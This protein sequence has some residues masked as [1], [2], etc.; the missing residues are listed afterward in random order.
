MSFPRILPGGKRDSAAPPGPTRSS[1]RRRVCLIG[2]DG[3]PY[4][5]LQRMLAEGVMPNL[6]ALARTGALRRMHS[7]YPWV[8]SVAWAS[9]MTGC[10]PAKHNIFGFIDR[11]PATWQ[12]FIPTADHMRAPTLWRLLSQA[13][14]RVVVLNVPVSY[15]V[16]SQ[17]VNGVLIGCFLSPRL[18]ERSVYPPSLLPKL[19]EL[20]YRIDTNPWLARQ[21]R[22]QILADILD[23]LEKRAATALYLLQHED[24][25]FFMAVLM[26]TD[27]LHHFF[28]RPMEEN[29]PTWAPA[30]FDL[31]RRIDQ[32]IG[33]VQARLDERTTLLLMSDHG[34]CS[35]KQE[36]FYNT[37]LADAGYL[38]YAVPPAT[39]KGPDLAAIDPEQS[40]AYS[41][42]PGRIFIN[43]AG[44]EKGGRVQPAGYERL[45]DELAAAAEALVD[46]RSGE[47]LV[48]KAYRREELYH[49]PYVGQAADLILAP[50]DGYDPKG[51]FG[52]ATLTA[53]DPALVGMHTYEDAFLCAA[54]V[55]LAPDGFG[56]VD[57]MP[58]ILELL[59]TPAPAHVD[60]RSLLSAAS[61]R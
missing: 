32:I 13:G 47:R 35:I 4:S 46:P 59:D 28:F 17:P 43:L 53:Q 34:F 55:E 5:L 51:A 1:S 45:R 38:K 30:F 27:R 56:I 24:W 49:G 44:R 26:E 48:L 22:S 20:G 40:L 7:V 10:N 16:T 61:G 11:H 60:G 9:C 6:A 15:P 31:Y 21:G 18:D 41:L 33:Q 2:L 23:A 12:T 57:V 36:V 29:D 42:D 54:G 58:T 3:L 37:W 19:A 14:K 8:S 50:V 52:K 39:I 25:D